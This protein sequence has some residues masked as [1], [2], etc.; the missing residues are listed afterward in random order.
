VIVVEWST[1]SKSGGVFSMIIDTLATQKELVNE[2]LAAIKVN[3]PDGA[4]LDTITEYA[5]KMGK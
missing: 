2:A 5:L 4:L 1:T 3:A